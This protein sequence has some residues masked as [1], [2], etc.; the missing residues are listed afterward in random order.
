VVDAIKAAEIKPKVL[1][2]SSAIGIYGPSED[3]FV[4]EENTKGDD[5]LAGVAQ[6]WEDAT[7]GAEALGVRRV[8]IRTGLVLSAKGGV[9][10]LLKLPFAFFLGGPLGNGRQYYSWIHIED[11]VAAIRFLL[12]NEHARGVYNLT[13]PNPVTNREFSRLLGK[14]MH[15]PSFV[16]VPG[17]V[18]NAVLGEAST[19]ALDGQ[20]VLPA[21]LLEAGFEYKYEQLRD[22][23]QDLAKTSADYHHAFRVRAPVRAVAEFHRHV[24]V[25]KQLTPFPIFIHFNHVE[26][27]GEGST[28]DF[29]LWFGPVPVRWVA[30]HSDLGPEGFTDTQVEGPFEHWVHRHEFIEIDEHSTE[31][32]DDIQAEHGRFPWKGLISRFMRITLPI[33]F[34]YRAWRTRQIVEKRSERS[35]GDSVEISD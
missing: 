1:I 25:L 16:P 35:G 13:A 28:V 34:A 29:T 3:E 8:I 23:L 7:R 5:F 26:P 22:A 31:V 32:V 18:M 12:E 27:M 2:Q 4:T 20:R 33:L 30:V 19:V 14:A 17:L 24:R 6:R 9:F 11:E 10:P 15:R 21:R